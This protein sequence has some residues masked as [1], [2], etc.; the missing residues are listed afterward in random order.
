MTLSFPEHQPET[1]KLPHPEWAGFTLTSSDLAELRRCLRDDL[2]PQADA[3][4]DEEVLEMTYNAMSLLW[5]LR[6][7]WRTQNSPRGPNPS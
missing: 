6:K 5:Q 1:S 2:G 3:W 4:S 7:L